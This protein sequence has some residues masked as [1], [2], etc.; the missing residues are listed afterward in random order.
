MNSPTH[1][2]LTVV[3]TYIYVFHYWQGCPTLV[4]DSYHPAT[5]RCLPSPT[6]QNQIVNQHLSALQRPG[7]EPF[8]GIRCV[9]AGTHLKVK[10]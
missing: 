9:E 7:Y 2:H 10:E 4:L 8:I 6:L 1:I 5:F 3:E